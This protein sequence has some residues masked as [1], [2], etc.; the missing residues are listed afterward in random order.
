[1]ISFIIL[2]LITFDDDD[3]DDDGEEIVELFCVLRLL[4]FLPWHLTSEWSFWCTLVDFLSICFL[5]CKVDY[6]KACNDGLLWHR[7]HS[8]PHATCKSILLLNWNAHYWHRHQTSLRLHGV[9]CCGWSSLLDAAASH[10]CA[11]PG[12]NYKSD[13]FLSSSSDLLQISVLFPLLCARHTMGLEL[14]WRTLHL[15]EVIKSKVVCSDK[16]QQ[17]ESREDDTFSINFYVFCKT[18]KNCVKK[19]IKINTYKEKAEKLVKCV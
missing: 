12:W 16:R 10:I 18:K 19:K 14:K 9:T 15:V 13:L 5:L 2:R 3:D 11:S 8:P 4:N 17:D 7:G 6:C 1:M